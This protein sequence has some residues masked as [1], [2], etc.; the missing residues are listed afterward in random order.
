MTELLKL[1]ILIE[2]SEGYTAEQI[3]ALIL[4]GH[5]NLPFKNI[6]IS[7][8]PIGEIQDKKTTIYKLVEG[9]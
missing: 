4:E 3:R 9:E 1:E 6:L 7:G 5:T 2:P 8:Q